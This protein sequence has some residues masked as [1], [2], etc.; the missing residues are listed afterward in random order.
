MTKQMQT[1]SGIV[2]DFK[3][4]SQDIPK[5]EQALNVIRALPDTDLWQNSQLMAH[6]DNIKTFQKI[7]KHLEMEDERQKSFAP[8]NVALVAKGSKPK[9]K[10]PFRGKQAKKGPHSPQNSRLGRGIAKKQKAK[11]NGAKS[12]AR[13]KC[14]NCGRKGH[15]SRIVPRPVR[16]LFL[17]KLLM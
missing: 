16:Y 1:L 7:P 15:Y 13:V 17:P 2:R 4:T 3:A 8:P 6:N 14:Y 5:D 10:R 12:I 11:G 9:G